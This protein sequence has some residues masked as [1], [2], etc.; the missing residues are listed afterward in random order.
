[1]YLS[2]SSFISQTLK[3][4]GVLMLIILVGLLIDSEFIAQHYFK[5]AQ[6][7]NN[8]GVVSLFISLYL[9]AP[10]RTKEQLIYAVLI[11]IIGEYLFSILLGMYAYRL[12]NIPHYI[13]VGH[14]ILFLYVYNFC[15]KSKVRAYRKNIEKTLTIAIVAISLYYL[16]FKQDVY[17]F[18]LTLMVFYFLRKYPKEKLFYLTMY[19]V[20]VYT[21]LIGTALNC[22]K[23]PSIAFGKFEFLP[24]ANPPIGISLFYFGLDRG[25]MSFYKRRH[26]AAW[27]R[28][29]KI[30]LLSV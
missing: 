27:K 23:W 17:G 26:K 8:I 7:I 11:A 6:W 9:K 15:K 3:T 29:K 19:S 5:N 25:T 1:M 22:W 16:I 24:S 13:P 14:A 21:E 18:L 10:S 4:I 12:G 30:R 20:I 28:L 2:S